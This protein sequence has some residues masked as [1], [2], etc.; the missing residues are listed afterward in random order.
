[1]KKYV[2]LFSVL[3]LVGVIGMSA[4][5]LME[6]R[7]NLIDTP[8]VYVHHEYPTED[9]S[10]KGEN[11]PVLERWKYPKLVSSLKYRVG[12]LLPNTGT[13]DPYW[14]T[15]KKGINAEATR[16]GINLVF[17]ETQGYEYLTEFQ[18]YFLNLVSEEVDGILL[19]SIHYSRMD[20]FIQSAVNQIPIVSIVNNIQSTQVSAKVR[21][22][23]TKMGGKIGK[24]LYDKIQ[25]KDSITIACFPG[26]LDAGWA[27]DSL[28][29]IFEELKA[30]E[31]KMDILPPKWGSPEFDVQY[32]F[33]KETLDDNLNIDIII[34]NAVAAK[35]AIKVL[36]DIGQLG[37]VKILS[38]YY[39]EN[40]R[41]DIRKGYI[42]AAPTDQ[43]YFIG[44]I[45]VGLL[46]RV[47]SNKEQ[48]HRLPLLVSPKV[49]MITQET[50]Q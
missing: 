5:L 32:K 3:L 35:A 34:G 29:G 44:E 39:T 41:E 11:E 4:F 50:L 46:Y 22:P 28:K 12:V 30:F 6:H 10:V 40:I 36:G 16:L 7:N 24:F 48:R 13:N 8:K 2:G 20:P 42:M 19:A 14:S 31:G 27:A 23:Y 18:N 45:G 26:P 43:P 9:A 49:K 37:Q 25:S 17:Y 38:T 33:I 47:L 21:V 15:I 1:V